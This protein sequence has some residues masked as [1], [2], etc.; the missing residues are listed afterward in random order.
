MV[1]IPLFFL[2]EFNPKNSVFLLTILIF[3]INLQKINC[4]TCK[5]ANS[6]N[7]TDCFN[8]IIEINKEDARYF[9]A[10]HFVTDKNGNLIIEYSGD[11][12]SNYRLF[13]ALKKNG[14]GY[15]NDA[16]IKEKQLTKT[17]NY[18]GRY[19][20]RNFLIHLYEDYDQE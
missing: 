4:I 1:D 6:L 7:Q 20:S 9:R 16:T 15:F 3:F 11:G 14:R 13:Y 10:G 17:G 18:I 8:H 19:E 5:E 2:F 12:P